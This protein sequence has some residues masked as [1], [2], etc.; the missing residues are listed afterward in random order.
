MGMSK[1]IQERLVTA[2]NGANGVLT[3]CVR[4]GNVLSSNGS[5]VPFFK[6]LLDKGERSLPVTDAAMTRFMLTLEQ[7]IDLVLFACANLKGGDTVVSDLPSFK[8][9]DLA[10]VMLEAYG[11]GEVRYVG[12][13]PGEKIHETL[14]SN[15]EMRR[16]RKLDGYYVVRGYTSEEEHL[17]NVEGEFS[18]RSARCMSREEIRALL[19]SEGLL[20]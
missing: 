8:V 19:V 18:S 9:V 2:M 15:E 4:Y 20:P 7:A 17:R 11:G 6:Q 1:A 16:A 10:E 3:G 13:R 12:I 14:L 5:V